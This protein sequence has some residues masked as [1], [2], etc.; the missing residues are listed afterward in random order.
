M[1]YCCGMAQIRTL[2]VGLIAA[3][4]AIVCCFSPILAALFGAVGLSALMDY[5]D[6]VPRPAIAILVAL[7]FYTLVRKKAI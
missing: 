3:L 4:A 2:T 5:L 7:A 6:Y 1:R